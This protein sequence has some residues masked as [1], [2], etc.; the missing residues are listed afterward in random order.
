DTEQILNSFYQTNLFH[1]NKEGVTLD[2]VPQRLRGELAATEIKD[3]KGKV[4]VEENR[5][6]SA[7]HIR[8]I[9][10][11]EINKLEM[12]DSYLHGK[13]IAKTI[14]DEDTGEVLAN[15]N[16]EINADLVAKLR[17]KGIKKLETLYINEIEC[18]PYVSDTLRLD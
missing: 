14:F 5:R 12:P 1:I 16:A 8:L 6:I 4:I 18:G 11:A 9:E 10:K 3:N 13:V 7:R 17:E 15:A 2:L